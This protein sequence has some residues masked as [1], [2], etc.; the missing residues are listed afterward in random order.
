MAISEAKLCRSRV[1]KY[2]DMFW[3]CRTKRVFKTVVVIAYVRQLTIC[4]RCVPPGFIP[5][6]SKVA[7]IN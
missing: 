1:V 6:N 3:H 7:G 4:R 5:T 2:L